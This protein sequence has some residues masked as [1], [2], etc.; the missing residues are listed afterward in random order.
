MSLGVFIIIFVTIL[1]AFWWLNRWLARRINGD[2]SVKLRQQN[3][4]NS[5]T[6]TPIS[7]S[8]QTSTMFSGNTTN[9]STTFDIIEAADQFLYGT[10][11]LP[12]H[13]V[14]KFNMQ[15]MQISPEWAE[16]IR[17]FQII[18]DSI[19]IANTSKKPDIAI[20]RIQV[21]HDSLKECDFSIM[22]EEK[23]DEY[24]AYIKQAVANAELAY[25]L[26]GAQALLDKA[27][28]LKTEKAKIKYYQ[29]AKDLLKSGV[30]FS[31]I[32]QEVLMNQLQKIRIED[33]HE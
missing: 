18:A 10:N 9:T 30:G 25:R 21:I 23:R 5:L 7:H 32:N 12:I 6:R 11:K 16:L 28:S 2:K 13:D 27:A 8:S 26:N 33:D 4:T 31:Y 17:C 14:A 22:S 19:H 15:L 29:Q 24:I 1:I 3:S 20:S